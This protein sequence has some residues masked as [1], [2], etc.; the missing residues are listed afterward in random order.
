MVWFVPRYTIVPLGAL[1]IV[2][3][4]VL[5]FVCA[6]TATVLV[7]QQCPAAVMLHTHVT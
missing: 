2:A 4:L 1:S 6:A 7:G 5:L 3:V